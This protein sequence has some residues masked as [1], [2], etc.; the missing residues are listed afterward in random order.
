MGPDAIG[1][2]AGSLVMFGLQALKT[3]TA[4]ATFTASVTATAEALRIAM[5]GVVRE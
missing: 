4:T 5:M 3:G 1:G 2:R